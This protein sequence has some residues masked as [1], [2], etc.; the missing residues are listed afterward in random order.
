MP[1]PQHERW[2]ACAVLTPLDSAGA[3]DVARLHDHLD[4]LL[5]R[6][7]TAL[8]LFGTTGEGPSFTVEE[9]IA[10]LD[11]LLRRG[12]D[13]GRV[14]VG[15]G[16]AAVP[17]TVR[18]TRHAAASGCGGALILPPFFFKGVEDDGVFDAYARTIE[19]LG[20]AAPRLFLYHIPSV[21]GVGLSLEV[22]GRVTRAFGER[23]A[24]VK[25]SSAEWSYTR[26][27]LE[28][29]PQLAVFVGYE[30]HVPRALAQGAAGTICGLANL[31]PNL[32]HRLVAGD[33][34][35][36]VRVEAWLRALDGFPVI[37]AHKAALAAR[38]DAP[39]WRAVRPPLVALS[40]EREARLLTRIAALVDEVG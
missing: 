1:Q 27:L 33:A 15:T 11:D 35:A 22:I 38:R 7:V 16:C 8:A 9:R 3:V 12:V 30:P 21:T 32:M 14:I 36:A 24:G 5:A 29:H 39:A 37:P 40:P 19:A 34:E 31:A 13:P 10:A 28:R 20:D 4:W 26:A 2:T 6:G 18:L 17:D 25:D 23:I